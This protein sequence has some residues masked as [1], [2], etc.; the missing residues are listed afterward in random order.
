MQQQPY[1]GLPQI[2]E[3]QHDVHTDRAVR[4][5]IASILPK[6]FFKTGTREAR[7]CP[8]HRHLTPP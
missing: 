3:V 8:A 1:H 7:A 6:D 5:G 4:H 2:T